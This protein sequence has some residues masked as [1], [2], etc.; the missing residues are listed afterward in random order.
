ML[1]REVQAGMGGLRFDADRLWF[2]L[3][4]DVG[5]VLAEQPAVLLG[6][7][8]PIPRHAPMTERARRPCAHV[9]RA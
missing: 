5:L 7:V 6:D 4:Y 9:T 3:P 1:T 8:A 2:D